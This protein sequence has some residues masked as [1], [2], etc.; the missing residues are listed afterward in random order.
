MKYT[1]IAE[2]LRT[3]EHCLATSKNTR[4]CLAL[5]HNKKILS[6]IMQAL[7]E[8]VQAS[9][10][11]DE[12]FKKQYDEYQKAITAILEKNC[13]RDAN[14]KLLMAGPGAYRIAP[15]DT[16]KVS[17]EIETLKETTSQGVKEY[18]KKVE[19]LQ[20]GDYEKEIKFYLIKADYLPEELGKIVESLLPIIE[21]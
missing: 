10:P 6:P 1:Q 11:K 21:S 17:E 15:E 18:I 4:F 2:L 13:M 8:T 19:D 3:I 20:N 9:T 16:A 12:M 7:E 14:G 5:A